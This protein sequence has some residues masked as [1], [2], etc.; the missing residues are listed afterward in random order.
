MKKI[1]SKIIP[2]IIC[3][4]SSA[5]LLGI[6]S[7]CLSK[8]NADISLQRKYKNLSFSWWGTDARNEYTLESIKNFENL[9][10]DIKITSKY[11]DWTG[12]EKRMDI[13]VASETEADVMQ[14]NY[15]WINKYSSDKQAFYDLNELSDVIDLTQFSDEVLEYG[16]SDNKLQAIPIALNS[17]TMYY[18]KTIYDSYGLEIPESLDDLY[19]AAEL[20]S[21]DNIYPIS[22][23]KKA[24]WFVSVA[25]EE[26]RT[27]KKIFD[28]NNNIM[29]T[30]KEL[31]ETIDICCDLIRKKVIP[32]LSKYEKINFDEGKYAGEVMWISDAASSF[33]AAEK[34][35]YEIVVGDYLIDDVDSSLS[36]Y[37]K[38]ATM[39]AISKNTEYPKE[40]ALLI[41]FLLNSK[42][43]ALNQGIEKGIPLSNNAR[44]VLEEN[45]MLKGIQYDAYCKLD[46]NINNVS[47][48]SPYFENS[49]LV[50][51]F[52][53]TVNK[54]LFADVSL[55]EAASE[56]NDALKNAA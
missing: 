32:E 45:N 9:H 50:E 14:I 51:T 25:I 52:Y 5:S 55:D 34:K 6:S 38:P 48:I 8:D 1:S 31:A 26:E 28:E 39:Y 20:M 54:V 7:G 49:N 10:P 42:E 16:M 43:M 24:S 33:D 56:L 40:S 12:Y 13:E 22:V 30:E 37:V 53:D 21:K 3:L 36:W 46:S 11:G 44:N 18:N 15:A 47:K 23:T 17:M 27:G 29:F 19:K 41:D 4:I 2:K 35:G